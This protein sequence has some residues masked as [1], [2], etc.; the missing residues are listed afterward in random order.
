MSKVP[1]RKINWD[2]YTFDSTVEYERYCELKLLQ[3]AGEITGLIVHPGFVLQ[4]G[5]TH[6]EKK[7]QP[8]RFTADFEYTENGKHVVE[9][10]KSNWT[11]TFTDYSIRRRMFLFQHQD[12]DFR[13]VVK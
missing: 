6:M 11:K 12:I 8:I 4:E 5:F 9:D 10:V 1:H 2:G 13:E 7:I 3:S